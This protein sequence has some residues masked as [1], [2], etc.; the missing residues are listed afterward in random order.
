MQIYLS[1]QKLIWTDLTRRKKMKKR[2]RNLSGMSLDSWSLDS[3]G[4]ETADLFKSTEADLDRPD[5]QQ[6]IQMK[7]WM[8][9]WI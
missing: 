8:N 6:E 9:L 7:D 3:L 5:P 1:Q 2:G 4:D